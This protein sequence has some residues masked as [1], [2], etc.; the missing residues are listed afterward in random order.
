M[1]KN[2]K[3]KI[4]EIVD[5]NLQHLTLLFSHEVLLLQLLAHAGQFLSKL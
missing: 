1:V 3:K 4:K 2:S 5:R